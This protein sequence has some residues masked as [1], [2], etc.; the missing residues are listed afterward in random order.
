MSQIN[1]DITI[2]LDGEPFTLRSSL[3]AA[4]SVSAAFGGFT[5][6]YQALRDGRL[7]AYQFII[8]AGA[9][10]DA[11]RK[12]STD[13]LNE[14]VWRTGINNLAEKAAKY[15]SLLQNGGRDLEEATLDDD[16][17]PAGNDLEV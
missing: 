14:A 10:K 7:D 4:T 1:S 6:A 12:M 11:M 15:V 17:R 8:R 13:D 5:A 2:L 16:E 3:K 9:T